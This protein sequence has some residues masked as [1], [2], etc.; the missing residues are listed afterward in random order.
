MTYV[1]GIDGGGSTVRVVV[2]KPDLTVVGKSSGETVN[3]SVIGQEKAIQ[4]IRDKIHEAISNAGLQA[5]DIDAISLGI[6]GT[7]KSYPK[8]WLREIAV[9]V[10]PQAHIVPASDY[11][12]ALVGAHGKPEGVLILAGTGSVAYG[13]NDKGESVQIGGW[14]YLLGDEGSG[15]WLGTEALKAI[16]RAADGRS[17][18][19]ILSS[20]LLEKLDISEV[21]SL[22]SWLYNPQ[23]Y[24]T[25]DV[26]K[27]APLVLE[28]AA[29]GDDVAQEIVGRGADELANHVQTVIR[30]L[31]ME[32]PPIAFTGGLLSKPNPLSD[33]LCNRLQMENIPTPRYSPVIGATLLALQSLSK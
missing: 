30:R 29:N 7:A 23:V 33:A 32:N 12:I 31:N 2:V 25:P 14:G 26:A 10:T 8:D 3:P 16:T 27:L 19:T 18:E 6:A 22:I 11:E 28:Q 13:V 17:P 5:E 20:V 15:Y 4:R 1:I 21:Q 24:R 9:A